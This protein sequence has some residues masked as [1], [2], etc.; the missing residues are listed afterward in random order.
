LNLLIFVGFFL[1]SEWYSYHFPELIKIVSDNYTYAMLAKFIG[2]RKQ[3]TEEKIE[4]L[5]QLV[6]DSEKARAIFD[7]S[8]SSMGMAAN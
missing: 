4:G 8:R 5:E 3:L 2:D 7:A 6:V 1:Y